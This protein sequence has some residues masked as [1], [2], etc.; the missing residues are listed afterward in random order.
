MGGNFVRKVEIEKANEVH[1]IDYLVA[2]GE[3]IQQTGNSY[4]KHTE[5]DSLVFNANGKWYWNSHNVGGFGA[6]SLA[7]ELY[8]MSFQEAVKDVNGQEISKTIERDSS[9]H[10]K[11]FTY[12]TQYEVKTIDNAM[13]YLTN[14]RKL[15][16]KIVLALQHHDLIAEDKL[17]NIVFKWRDKD[18]NIVGAN[19][20]GTQKIENKHGCFK[21][22][23]PNSKADYGFT[24]D[25]GEPNKLAVFESPID[26]LSYFD[27][28]R[29]QNIRLLSMSGLKDQVL[30]KG[31][32]E[33]AKEL[34]AREEQSKL[35]VI[36]AVD[37]DKAGQTFR[38]KWS[39]IITSEHLTFDI[40]TEK[41]WNDDLK[42]FR[43]EQET[44]QEHTTQKNFSENT[45]DEHAFER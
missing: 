14:E 20:Q 7:R 36:I 37:N 31:M 34:H 23:M 21:Q 17:K 27:L 8:G 38:E 5:H 30:L 40:P 6:I 44:I 10:H 35:E 43:R 9:E 22:I 19:R 24:L 16:S 32:R 39:D 18:G 1:V 33:L 13:N 12:P 3:P 25:I 42:K 4:F 29:P 28:K 15:D 26:A 45:L 11:K 2:K 41:D